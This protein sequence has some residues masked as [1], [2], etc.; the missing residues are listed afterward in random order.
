[1]KTSDMPPPRR[2]PTGSARTI[3]ST[4]APRRLPPCSR[5]L[6]CLRWGALLPQSTLGLSASIPAEH[7]ACRARSVDGHPL[8]IDELKGTKPTEKIDLSNKMLGVASAIIIASCI[9]GNVSL[10]ELLCAASP[11]PQSVM[12]R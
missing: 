8:P 11:P 7:F 6:S 9:K 12:A 10:K 5:T 3:S 4:R 2:S 1:M